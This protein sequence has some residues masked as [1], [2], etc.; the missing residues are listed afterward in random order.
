LAEIVGEYLHKGSKVYIEGK[1]Q[2]RKW[3]NKDGVDMYT[4]E[5]VAHEM[6]MLDNKGGEVA[7]N[8]A[9]HQSKPESDNQQR[10][11]PANAG[12]DDDIPF[13]LYERSAII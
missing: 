13:D 5:I 6:Q 8:S 11:A 12:F 9:A 1:L 2:T 10:P 3:Q 7:G 4:T